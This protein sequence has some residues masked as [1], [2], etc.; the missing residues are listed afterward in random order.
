[1]QKMILLKY[2]PILFLF[3]IFNGCKTNSQISKTGENSSM[4][5]IKLKGTIT[6]YSNKCKVDGKCSIQVNNKWTVILKYGRRPKSFNKIPKGKLMNIKAVN[7][8]S[9]IG[10]KVRIYAK[11]SKNNRLTIEGNPNFYVKLTD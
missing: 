1:M 8:D 7:N 6:G 3:I 10:K 9:I 2:A 11:V 4:Q 5:T